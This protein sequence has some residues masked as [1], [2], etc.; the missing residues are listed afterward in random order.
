[1]SILKQFSSE[2]GD[3]PD[4]WFRRVLRAG[5]RP[6]ELAEALQNYLEANPHVTDDGV[7]VPNVFLLS[8]GTA[9]H[10]RLGR[11]GVALPRA[12]GTVVVETADVRGWV[13]TGPVKVRID[14]DELIS[15]GAY[16][17]T[18]RIEAVEGWTSAVSPRSSGPD[19]LGTRTGVLVAPAANVATGANDA[20]DTSDRGT[21][22]RGPF[23]PALTVLTGVDVGAQ[24][25]LDG[26]RV[27]AGRGTGCDLMIRDTTVSREHAAFVQRGDTWWVIDL[28]STN[29]TRVNG[30]RAAEHP[31]SIG[32]RIELGDVVVE[33]VEV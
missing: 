24:I 16:R 20:A 1:M 4:P 32:D 8:L 21:D 22:R 18:G 33:L 17:L 9:D 6:V 2:L 14:R 26:S 30:L 27:T 7:L 11:Y 28:G 23:D 3:D 13:L 19:E 31:L 10:A 5:V 15:T 12:L 29:G 25:V